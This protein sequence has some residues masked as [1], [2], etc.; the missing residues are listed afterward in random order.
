M[1]VK[2]VVDTRDKHVSVHHGI[3]SMQCV[4]V[5]TLGQVTTMDEYASAQAIFIEEAQFF[6]DVVPVV[7]A[8]LRDGKEV[9]V[10]ALDADAA[11]RPWAS[12]IVHL[13]TDATVLRKHIAMC[14]YCGK[15]APYTVCNERLPDTQVLIGGDDIYSAVC[16]THL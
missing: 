8:M 2:P 5:D 6:S 16:L 3:G 4:S 11:Q 7:R 1:V 14:T 12:N 15:P 13:V 10:Y 9:Y